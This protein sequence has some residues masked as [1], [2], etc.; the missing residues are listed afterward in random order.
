MATTT[1]KKKTTSPT[2]TTKSTATK[3]KVTKPAETEAPREPGK[4]QVRLDALTA[5]VIKAMEQGTFGSWVKK[6]SESPFSIGTNFSTQHQYTGSNALI[7]AWY[8]MAQSKPNIWGTMNAGYSMGWKLRKG[9]QQIPLLRPK[10][11]V[12]SAE[13]SS[14][15]KEVRFTRF[16][17]FG[18]SNLLDF[19]ANPNAKMSPVE[20]LQELE[21]ATKRLSEKQRIA[22]AEKFLNA[23]IKQSGVKMLGNGNPS[24]APKLDG[25]WMPD[26]KTFHAPE[27]YY[28]TLGHE[29]IHSTGAESRLARKGITEFDHFGSPQYAQEE[30]IAEL[31]SLFLMAY[32]GLEY[33]LMHKTSYL[34]SWL[35]GLKENPQYLWKS[36]AKAQAAY[37]FVREM[38]GDPIP[39]NKKQENEK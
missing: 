37:K 29:L 21:K 31:G 25:I 8:S 23:A 11:V 14:T 15:G 36:A 16:S 3:A 13:E 28:S 20:F 2:K 22:H 10:Q 19:D 30:L 17:L 4:L 38:G 26:F 7:T 39:E 24:Y 33:D 27:Y 12:I 18:V 1:A 35:N 6:W 34:A 9:S 5:D 32:L